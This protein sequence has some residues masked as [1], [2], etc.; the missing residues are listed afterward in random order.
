[1][2]VRCK[3]RLDEIRIC[4]STRQNV[5]GKWV[6]V[7]L[8]TLIF[9]PVSSTSPENKLFWAATPTG[10]IQLGMVN[11]EAWQRFELGHEYYFDASPAAAEAPQAAQ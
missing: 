10:Q 7:E 3:F 4:T 2:T 11:P 9:N 1:M 6:P 5:E 8:R